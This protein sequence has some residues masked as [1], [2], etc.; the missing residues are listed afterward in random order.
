M[1]KYLLIINDI[2]L[3]L[4]AITGAIVAVRGLSAWK[5]QL[6]GKAEYELAHRLLKATYRLREAVRLV[7]SP[8][9]FGGEMPEP[10]EGHPAA[11]SE[12]EKRSY[13]V[14]QAYEKRWENVRKV[15]ID[16]EAELIEA[17]V[18]WGTQVREKF[19]SLFDVEH[20]LYVNILAYLD[21]INP[22]NRERRTPEEAKANRL[23][24]YGTGSNDDFYRRL[25]DSIA[26]IEIELKPHLKRYR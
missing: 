4:A 3:S 19:L 23:I 14:T 1:E 6:S 25:Q 12:A 13:G 15:H 18:L 5:R 9:M 11:E 26:T 16:I 10:P 22:E 2:I 21:H 17:E 20:D 7:R 8:V 24:L